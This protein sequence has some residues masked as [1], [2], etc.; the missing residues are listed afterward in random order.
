M[1]QDLARWRA[2]TPAA[3]AGRVHL[4]NA[5]AA[6]MPRQVHEAI[7]DHLKRETALGGY[8]ASDYAADDIARAYDYVGT[9]IGT[10]GNNIAMVGNAT[11]AYALA[12]SAFDFAPGDVIL[13][14]RNDYISNQLAFL[15]LA[16]RA[17]IEFVRAE[18]LAE[19]GVDPDSVRKLIK[20]RRPKLV[21]VT[22]IPTNSGLVQPARAVGEICAETEVPYLVDAC[23]A[24]GQMPVDV[25]ALHCDFLA[26]TARKF[27]RGPR[28]AGFL[29]VSDRVLATDMHPLYVDMRGANW[30]QAN[31]YELYEGARRFE[32]WEF[33]YALVLGL[34][35]AARY[36]LA[37]GLE[38]AQTRA[39]ELARYA[40]EK[41]EA[42]D[43][44]RVLDRGTT[45]CAIVTV[46]VHGRD[47]A[48][49]VQELREWGINTS[50]TARDFAVLDM[51]DKHA[52]S[53]VRISPHYY[54]T[55][56]EIDMFV[57]SI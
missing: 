16:R 43:D 7:T 46:E 31:E 47:A 51:D 6:L 32:N 25:Q 13:T 30:T 55:R 42:R 15:S 48:E 49:I 41:L 50:L 33:A 1:D 12:L 17:G 53:A 52:T 2:D 34:G 18:D 56:E 22:W 9:V 24:V 38:N 5:G 23:Q 27:L 10:R 14:T 40:R 3:L 29:Y 37:V 11:E 28:G 26:A 19:G 54:N 39:W 4:N 21:S 57:R 45:K 44:V 36:A 8:E 35:E 20:A